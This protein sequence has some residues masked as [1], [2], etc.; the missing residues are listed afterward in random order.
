MRIPTRRHVV[1]ASACTLAGATLAAAAVGI[2]A[3]GSSAAAACGVLFDDFAYSSRTDPALA[4]R[5]WSVRGARGGPGVPGATWS[6]DGLTFPT[7][8]GQRVAQLRAATDGTPSGTSHTEFSLSDRR[9]FEG[10]YLARIRF[11]DAPESGT[12]GD[13]VNQ[14][15]YTIS[16]LRYDMDPIYSELDFSEYLPNGGWGTT[17]A[18]NFQTTWYTYDAEPWTADS[19]HSQQTRS[20]DGWHD[21]MATVAGGTVTYYIDGQVVGT[22]GGKYYPR[23]NMSIDFNQWFIDLTGHQ[24][25]G[26]SVWKQSVDYVMHAK[27]QVLTPAQA[28]EMVARYRTAETTHTDTVTAANDCTPPPTTPPPSGMS[29][30]ETLQAEAASAQSGTQVETTTDAGGGSNVGYVADGDWLRY[31]AVDF[32]ATSPSRIDLRVASGAAQGT[33]GRVEVRLDSPTGPL[34]GTAAV[35]RTGGWQSWTTVPA[36]VAGATG[37]RAVYL[38]FRSEQPGDFVNLN[39]VR[40]AYDAPTALTLQAEAHSAQSGTQTEPATDTGGGSGVGY[41]ANGDWLRFDGV[42]LGATSRSRVEL[43]VANGAPAGVTGRV[44]VR[45]DSLDGPLVATGGVSGTGGWQNW[46]TVSAPAAAA[47]GRRS[48]FVSFRSDQS[49]DFVNLNW[50]RFS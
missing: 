10:T 40:F 19:Q 9:F 44:E 26:T 18:T 29:A 4:Q 1:P 7:V 22:H 30:R 16:P 11:S 20:M 6:P 45:L 24:G 36:A 14:T 27:K 8:D 31:D 38:S 25:T 41:V 32:G 46:T 17:S 3:P 12:D 49:G 34:V 39:W 13:I 15:F 21:V 42:E 37:R 35:T 47:T 5:G 23:Q 33:T 43:R 50:L 28:Q 48:V 2:T